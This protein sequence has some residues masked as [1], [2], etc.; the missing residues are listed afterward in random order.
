MERCSKEALKMLKEAPLP[1]MEAKWRSGYQEITAEGC[2]VIQV[3][4]Q[5]L[6]RHL[7]KHIMQIMTAEALTENYPKLPSFYLRNYLNFQTHFSLSNLI[8]AYLNGLEDRR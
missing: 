1:D 6:V 7:I 4:Q 5:W 3:L 2:L 8:G